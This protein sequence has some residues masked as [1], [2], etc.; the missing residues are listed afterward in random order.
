MITITAPK[1]LFNEAKLR[2]A[3]AKAL[4]DA[5]DDVAADLLRPTSTWKTTVK[6][7]I[8]RIVDARSIE[9]DNAIYG[10][11]SG[12]TRPHIIR[13]KNAKYLAFGSAFT[14]KTRP[15]TLTSGSGSRGPVDTFVTQVHHP[16]TEARDYDEQAAKIAQR[17][18]P[19]RM[20]KA[21]KEALR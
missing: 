15:G 3:C 11:V 10:Y 18:Y 14:P 12:G 16:G 7:N 20:L 21:V 2:A 13:A 17:D 9:V 6:A 8:K 5:A 1:S 4:D 19:A